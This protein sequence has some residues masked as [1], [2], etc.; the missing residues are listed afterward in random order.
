MQTFDQALFNL[1]QDGKISEEEALKNADSANNVRL[2]IKFAKE[3]GVAGE[4]DMGLS[5]E[6][7]EVEE[8]E[9]EGRG[10]MLREQPRHRWSNRLLKTQDECFLARPG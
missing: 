7:L 4:D 3:G 8:A 5:I 9:E 1:F 6:A 2:K 10:G